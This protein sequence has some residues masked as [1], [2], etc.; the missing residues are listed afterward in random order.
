MSDSGSPPDRPAGA[1]PPSEPSTPRTGPPRTDLPRNPARTDPARTRPPGAEGAESSRRRWSSPLRMPASP[2]PPL[3]PLPSPEPPSGFGRLPI[4]RW[5]L[6]AGAVFAVLFVAAATITVVTLERTREARDELVDVIDPA[7][8]YSL[9]K[10]TAFIRQESAVRGY[11]LTK[12]ERYRRLYAEARRDEDAA[13]A[14]I[15]GLIPRLPSGSAQGDA[16]LLREHSER[17][18]REY[19][20]PVIDGTMTADPARGERLFTPI[21]DALKRQQDELKRLHETGQERL[22]YGWRTFYVVLAVLALVLV[23]AAIA[24]ALLIRFAVLRPVSQLAEQVRAVA[25]GDFEHELAVGRPAELAD[26]SARVDA[27]RHRMLGEWRRSAQAEQRLS[28]QT[29]ELRRSNAELEQFA[30]VAS[31]DLQEPLR[32]V[33]SFTQMLEQRYGEHLDDRARQ[34]IAFA[35]DGAKRMQM[36]INDLLDFSRVGRVGGEVGPV[37]LDEVLATVLDNLGAQIE[38]ADARVTADPLPRV[39]GNRVLLGQLLQNLIGNA[40]KFRSPDPPRIHIGA[41][42]RGGMWEFSC[43]DNGIGV[44][45]KYAERIF[46][47]FQRLHA[48]DVYPGTGIGLALCKKIV[49]YH[50]GT[51]WIDPTPKGETGAT[52]RWTLPAAAD[53]PETGTPQTGTPPAAT[54]APEPPPETPDGPRAAD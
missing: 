24:F 15:A 49:E 14:A 21:L 38:D 11:S 26:L 23:A 35:V 18:H 9:E 10:A 1:S 47:I 28:E 3:A 27:M 41:V 51:I 39:T 42:R 12:D 45:A 53:T 22:E 34:Y 31:H 40:I 30:Y 36:L 5:F 19:A 2:P 20:D 17:W 32:K 54:A 46:L 6:I 8:L 29:L 37:D 13:M 7:A 48:R 50:G 43:A 25:S 4:R 16:T 52:F 33:A 44:D